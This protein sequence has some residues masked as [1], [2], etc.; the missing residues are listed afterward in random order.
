MGPG[1]LASTIEPGAGQAASARVIKGI[2]TDG[3]ERLIQ[4]GLIQEG[5]I[6]E[7]AVLFACN[8]RQCRRPFGD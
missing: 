1:L 6:Q 3:R 4:E 7:G 8:S 2:G 5:F